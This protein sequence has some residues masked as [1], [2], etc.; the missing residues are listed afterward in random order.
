MDNFPSVHTPHTL[1][2]PPFINNLFCVACLNILFFFLRTTWSSFYKKLAWSCFGK[3]QAKGFF[4]QAGGIFWFACAQE[5]GTFCLSSTGQACGGAATTGEMFSASLW[6]PQAPQPHFASQ[7][8][9]FQTL[10]RW[11]LP[12]SKTGFPLCPL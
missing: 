12:G 1:Q 9:H 7:I 8:P 5:R 2:I 11:L 4:W 6:C 10:C 3:C